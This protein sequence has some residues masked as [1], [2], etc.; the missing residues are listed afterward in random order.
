MMVLYCDGNEVDVYSGY[1][2]HSNHIAI[3]IVIG[4]L[5]FIIFT[6]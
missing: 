3:A 6:L 5:F 2:G 1:L 4:L